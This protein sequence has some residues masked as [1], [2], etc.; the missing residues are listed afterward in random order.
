MLLGMEVLE[1][2]VELRLG[3]GM[4]DCLTRAL[5]DVFPSESSLVA[6]RSPF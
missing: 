3:L 4:D 6:S 5:G 2:W 1:S